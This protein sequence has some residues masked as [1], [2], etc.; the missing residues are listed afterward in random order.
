MHMCHGGAFISGLNGLPSSKNYGFCAG[1]VD[2]PSDA[3]QPF[4]HCELLPLGKNFHIF[5]AQHLSFYFLP[6]LS[7]DLMSIF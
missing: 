5:E 7:L 6:F 3:G 4:E 1:A 2:F